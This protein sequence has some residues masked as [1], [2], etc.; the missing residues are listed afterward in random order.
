MK[1]LKR[2]NEAVL[3]PDKI[4]DNVTIDSFESA[5]E[6]GNRNNFDVVGYD[7]FYNSLNDVDKKTAPPRNTP[8]FALFSPARKKPMFVLVAKDVFKYMYNFKEIMLDIIGHERVHQQQSLRKGDIQYALPSPLNKKEYFSNKEEIMAFSWTI[9]NDLSKVTNN[10]D[11][12]IKKLKSGLNSQ[13]GCIWTDIK[14]YCDEKTINRY[15]KYIYLY[16]DKIFNK[17]K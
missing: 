4:E 16:L 10:V 14:K 13:G 15:K 6:F 3:M 1:H 17:E 11:S 5:V 8:F 9:A 7:E 2:F 12:A